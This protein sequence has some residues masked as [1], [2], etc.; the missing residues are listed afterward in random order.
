MAFVSS[1]DLSPDLLTLVRQGTVNVTVTFTRT[2]IDVSARCNQPHPR[3]GVYPHESMNPEIIVERLR[4]AIRDDS[5]GDVLEDRMATLALRAPKS[6]IKT[7]TPSG[8]V[9]EPDLGRMSLTHAAQHVT[10]RNL[11]QVTRDNGV[12]NKLPVCS[13][14]PYDVDRNQ[15]DLMARS[16]LVAAELGSETILSRIRSQNELFIEGIESLR[17]WWSVASVQQRVR[18]LSDRKHFSFTKTPLEGERRLKV[19]ALPCPF[20]G[21]IDEKVFEEPAQVKELEGEGS[22]SEGF[23]IKLS[24]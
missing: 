13:L 15:Y 14:T 22:D 2:G 12:K 19:S 20:R 23:G 8:P 1:Y 9:V 21:D 5:V 7:E 3:L 6:V 16:V 18:V 17:E 4:K 11:M 10:S 24:S